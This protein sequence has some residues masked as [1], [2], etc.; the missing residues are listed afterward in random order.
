MEGI[1]MDSIEKVMEKSEIGFAKHQMIYDE[2]GKP[3]D[4]LFLSLNSAFERLT[5]LKREDLLNRRVTEV[6][7]KVSDDDFDWIG[8]YGKV[9]S[10]NKKCVFEQYSI[11]LD[12]WY[13][14]ECFSSEKDCFITIT[15][16]I[17]EQKEYERKLQI[18]KEQAES[19]NQA[20]SAF[21]ANMNHALRTPLNG[22]IGF[23]D[24]LRNTPLNK[25]QHEYVDIVYTSGKYLS[26]IISDILDLSRIEAGKFELN[27]D[28]TD[29]KELIEET[30]SIVRPKAKKK[31]LNLCASIEN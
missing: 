3:I 5:G 29:L 4:Y 20:K 31:S 27:P 22:I 2:G 11:P 1:G 8:Y 9:I 18:A 17:T 16:D 15:T 13:R 10:E 24:I 25:E 23:T 21:L 19:A 28:K 7:P 14:V 26:D 12:K 30:L 6:M